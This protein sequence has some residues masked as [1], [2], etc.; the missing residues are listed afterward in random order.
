M[1]QTKPTT[2]GTQLL[3][4]AEPFSDPVQKKFDLIPVRPV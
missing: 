3:L 2:I 4:H 1:V